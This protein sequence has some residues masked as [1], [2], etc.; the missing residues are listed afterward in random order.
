MNQSE[1]YNLM[2]KFENSDISEM[3]IE[4]DGFRIFLKSSSSCVPEHTHVLPSSAAVVQSASPVRGETTETSVQ[5]TV[6]T[7]AGNEVIRALIVGTFYRSP[8]PD[9]PPFVEVGD[10]VKEGGSICIIEA[11]KIMNKQE[12]EFPCEIVKILAENGQMVEY[13][14]PL[15]EVKRI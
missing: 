3:E 12:A 11:M 5:N 6:N 10:S 9:S 7:T 8:S 13:G 14:E 4:Q 2:E 1:I 15:F